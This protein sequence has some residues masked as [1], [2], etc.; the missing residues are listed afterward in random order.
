MGNQYSPL[1]ARPTQV[2]K[3]L[4]KIELT[5]AEPYA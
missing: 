4:M 1:L 2:D 3:D 5:E